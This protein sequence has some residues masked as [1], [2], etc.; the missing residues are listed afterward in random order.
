MSENQEF[1]DYI[2][3]EK[4]YFL[5][6]IFALESKEQEHELIKEFAYEIIY[7]SPMRT[8]LNFCHM[9]SFAQFDAKKI[10]I[11]MTQIFMHEVHNFLVDDGGFTQEEIES[12][13]T[14]KK[15]LQFLYTISLEYFKQF[16][17]MFY[18]I[19]VDSFFDLLKD[20]NSIKEIPEIAMEVVKGTV[21]HRSLMLETKTLQVANKPDQIWMQVQQANQKITKGINSLTSEIDSFEKKAKVLKMKLEAM[22]EAKKLTLDDLEEY[23]IE[24]IRDI[25]TE[26]D[27]DNKFERLILS[28][29]S[30]G[31]MCYT[32]EQKAER[33][34]I[35]AK[36]PSQKADYK[37]IM[38]FFKSKKLNNTENALKI[39]Y[40]DAMEELPKREKSIETRKEKLAVIEEKTLDQIE[41][42]LKKVKEVMVKNLM[43]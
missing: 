5:D 32:M 22:D 30:A 2:F 34:M 29:L 9:K 33:G 31:E 37:K 20:V 25:F 42:F 19:V 8:R 39:H 7:E 35:N 10:P 13:T 16:R 21:K 11:Q 36:L 24:D 27:D 23:S 1:I 15:H 28:F 40:N 3:S 12:A 38:E 17:P 41:P 18:K 43:H 4:Q 14:D 6:E 26:E